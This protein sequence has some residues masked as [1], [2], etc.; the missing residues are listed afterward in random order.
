MEFTPSHVGICVSDLDRSMQ[1]YC[2]G[3]G[4]EPAERYELSSESMP[5]I[6]RVMEIAPPVTFVSQMIRRGAVKLELLAYSGNPPTGSPSASR[7]QLGFTHLSFFV[8]D[9]DKAA[10]VLVEHGGT[11]LEPTRYDQGIQLVF[12]ADPDGTRV[13]LM[14]GA[15][16]PTA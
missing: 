13:E 4:F 15:P 8:D 12:L 11:V 14:G 3:L 9:V 7:A 5:G 1:F 10:R 16:P 6:D 2:G